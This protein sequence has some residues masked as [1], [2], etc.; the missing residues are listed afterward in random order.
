LKQ[1]SKPEEAWENPQKEIY[2]DAD[3]LKAIRS[4]YKHDL[5]SNIF[6]G[7]LLL[8]NCSRFGRIA[9]YHTTKV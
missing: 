7:T 5:D 3:F 2:C 4:D 6:A 1:A 8:M 9:I